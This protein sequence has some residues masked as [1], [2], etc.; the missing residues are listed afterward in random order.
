MGSWRIVDRN[1]GVIAEPQ[2]SGSEPGSSIERWTWN[3]S[4]QARS[5]LFRATLGVETVREPVMA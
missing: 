4:A 2:I 1:P 3:E 5:E